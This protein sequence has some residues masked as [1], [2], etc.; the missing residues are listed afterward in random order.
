MHN[1]PVYTTVPNQQILMFICSQTK[2]KLA[3]RE[4]NT[5]S[6]CCDNVALGICIIHTACKLIVACV[7]SLSARNASNPEKSHQW[8]LALTQNP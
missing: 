3:Y 6:T 1:Y 7:F 2:E 4:N 5:R 8:R